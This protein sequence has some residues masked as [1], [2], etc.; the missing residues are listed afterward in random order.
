M[1]RQ[2]SMIKHNRQRSALL[3]AAGITA[4]HRWEASIT[5]AW[6]TVCERT[7]IGCHGTF[8]L[9]LSPKYRGKMFLYGLSSNIRIR[10][11]GP[12]SVRNDH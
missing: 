7:T 1:R 5:A 12:I 4:E 9:R 8:L 3:H 10:G 11:Q 2:A 6:L